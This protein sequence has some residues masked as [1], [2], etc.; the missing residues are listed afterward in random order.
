MNETTYLELI[1]GDVKV[2]LEHI[3]DGWSGDYNEDDPDDDPILRF[4]VYKRV[5]D[6]CGSEW[7][8]VDNG[9]YCT[10]LK[11]TTPRWML[12]KVLDRIMWHVK[13]S[14]LSGSSIKRTCEWFSWFSEDDFKIAKERGGSKMMLNDLET[15]TGRVELARYTRVK[16]GRKK[17]PCKLLRQLQSYRSN[18]TKTTAF[19]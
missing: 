1:D 10:R 18:R 7:E 17:K 16:D 3:G 15:R 19:T 11:T 14:V 5:D 4:D 2:T 12:K 13:D 8:P 6:Y 9:S